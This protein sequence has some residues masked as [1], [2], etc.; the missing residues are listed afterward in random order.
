MFEKDFRNEPVEIRG[1]KVELGENK[2]VKIEID[3]LPTG[4]AIEIPIYIFN[5]K[6]AG[7]TILL[8]AGLHGD[9][10]NGIELVR[11]ML[12][13][14]YFNIKRGCV[15]VV[16]LL[17][18]FGF[19]H[20]SRDVH[21]KDVNRSFPGS[22]RGSLAS[23]IAYVLMREIVNNID[24][25]ID[26]HTG[27]NQRSNYPQIR[28]TPDNKEGKKL[29]DIFNAPYQFASKLI[30]KSFRKE[31]H[32]HN[33]PI[34]VYEGGEALRLNKFAIKKGIEGVLNILEY[35]EM[36]DKREEKA[37]TITIELSQRRWMRARIAGMF[38]IRVKN[39]EQVVKGQ[40]LGYITD[41]YG[42]STI[43]VKSLHDGY[44][45]AINNFPVISR[46]EAIFHIGK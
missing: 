44:I 39:G 38:N 37:E 14:N 35:F 19:L 34:I 15:I 22:K 9:E 24:F 40:T 17:N 10:V 11:K 6:E 8:Q 5:G 21:G 45:I 43:R 26:I 4:T 16:P 20:F 29:A 23:R 33:I 41:T 3:R 31:A 12:A 28:Y 27:A 30:P 36:I 2:L 7:P 42:E 32:K 13:K 18:V 25:G 1:Q 46:G